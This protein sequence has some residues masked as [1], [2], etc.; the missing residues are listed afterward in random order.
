[1]TKEIKI[2]KYIWYGDSGVSIEFGTKESVK[3][4]KYHQKE[5]EKEGFSTYEDSIEYMGSVTPDI[6]GIRR[7]CAFATYEEE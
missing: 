4:W 1:M 7:L 3:D 5:L 6:D 2:Y